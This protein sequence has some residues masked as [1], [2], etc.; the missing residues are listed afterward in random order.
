KGESAVPE[1][2]QFRPADPDDLIV[3]PT[4]QISTSLNSATVESLN[5]ER[6]RSRISPQRPIDSA[7]A[8]AG[9]QETLRA[10]VRRTAAVTAQPGPPPTL[11]VTKEEQR[12][13]YRLQTLSIQSEPGIEL[14]AVQAIPDGAGAKP[15]VVLLDELPVER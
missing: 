8:L 2:Q 13:S 11:N 15:A 7:A 6:A 4:G 10:E 12:E 14:S 3:T 1:F 5:R 9:F